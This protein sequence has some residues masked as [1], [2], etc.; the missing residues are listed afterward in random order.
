MVDTAIKLETS[1]RAARSIPAR[2]RISKIL[3]WLCVIGAV[4]WVLFPL[5]WAVITSFKTQMQALEPT[6][7]P[8]VQ[9]TPTLENWS[10]E[11]GLGAPETFA[12]LGNSLVIATGA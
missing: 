3:L 9:F 4:L 8:W 10:A 6:F 7:I 5:V 12:A 2:Q 11:L 1:S